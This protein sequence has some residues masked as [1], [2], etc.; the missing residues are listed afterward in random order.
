MIGKDWRDELDP[1]MESKLEKLLRDTKAYENAYKSS[2][3]RKTAQLWVALAQTYDKIDM[4]NRRLKRI[5]KVLVDLK[6]GSER[7][8]KKI[9]DK[10]LRESLKQY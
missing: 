8:E 2:L 3:D 7:T 10:K 9:K 6:E 5:E 4:V 1:N